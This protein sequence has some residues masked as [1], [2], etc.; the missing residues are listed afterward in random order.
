MN[1]KIIAL[2]LAFVIASSIFVACKKNTEQAEQVAVIVTDENGTAVTDEN[3]EFVTEYA[4]PVTDENGKNVTEKATNA[5]GE[6]L[7]DESGNPKTVVVT[8]GN[9]TTA[10]PQAAEEETTKAA[11]EQDEDIPQ[12]TIAPINERDLDNWTFGN[13]SNVGCIAPNGWNN[14]T[15]NQV[16]KVGTDIRVQMCPMNYLKNSGYKTADDYA[17]FFMQMAEK[18]DGKPKKLAY[19]KNVYKEG[20][21]ISMVYQYNKVTEDA[22]GYSYGKFHT[23]YIYQTGGKVRV[24]FVFGN[25]E[26]E[27]K[28]DITSVIQN[29][30]YR[31]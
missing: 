10:A 29:T 23:T 16:V 2:C 18:E 15:V 12:T 30:Y 3:G 26:Q 6:V 31:G 8:E 19:S 14:E 7:T 22:S 1:Q 4:T 13:G 17:K 25:T 24:F 5:K 11:G 27:A 9:N 28:T 20:T 21:A